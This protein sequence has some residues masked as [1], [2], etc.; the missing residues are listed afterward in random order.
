M[1]KKIIFLIFFF[2]F[3][4][5]GAFSFS[6][7]Q[8]KIKVITSLFPLQEFAQEVGG[9]QAEV[10]LLLPPGAEPHTWEPKPSDVLKIAQADIFIFIGAAMEPWADKA[11]KA[12]SGKKLHLLDLIRSLSLSEKG[13]K[14]DPHLW[15]DFTLD[16]K[17]IDLIA[18]ALGK[19]APEQAA[20]FHQNAH[21][22]QEKLKNLDQKYQKVL[23]TCRQRSFIL[24]GHAAFGYL[25][26]RYGLQQIALSGINPNAE[27]TPKRMAEIIAITKKEKAKFIFAEEMVNPRLAKALAKEAGVQILILN[28]GAN[29]TKKQQAEKVT[30]LHLMERN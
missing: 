23:A 25:A 30:F 7:G 22:Y 28:P 14:I 3:I 24:G 11:A 18:G 21:I 2:F 17:I 15:L 6:Y 19:I 10:T 5:S 16:L 9:K 20:S 13:Q 12:A 27:P 8:T 1:S 4:L 29:L 26:K